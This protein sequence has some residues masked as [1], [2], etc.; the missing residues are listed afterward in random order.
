MVDTIASVI[1]DISS[2]QMASP[3]LV[4]SLKLVQNY[5]RLNNIKLV[6]IDLIPTAIHSPFQV[7]PHGSRLGIGY[8]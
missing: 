6:R 5:Y 4:I 1:R 8:F 2:T 3:V 7:T